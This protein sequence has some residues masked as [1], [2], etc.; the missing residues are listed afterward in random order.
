MQRPTITCQVFLNYF[1]NKKLFLH[2]YRVFVHFIPYL[3]SFKIM[4]FFNIFLN[5]ALKVPVMTGSKGVIFFERSYHCLNI[6]KRI[7]FNIYLCS[8]C[9]FFSK[10]VIFR[11]LSM[12]KNFYFINKF[13]FTIET[14]RRDL[15]L[16]T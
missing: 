5:L 7:F 1:Y 9:K 15:K 13:F 14:S 8:R 16:T 11:Y 12:F 4:H 3:K 2:Q 10:T 6:S